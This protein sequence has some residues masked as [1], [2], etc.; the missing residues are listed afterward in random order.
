VE[1]ERGKQTDDPVGNLL[2]YLRETVLSRHPDPG[3]HVEATSY[4]HEE[5]AAVE[6]P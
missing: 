1:L 6:T 4:P 3:K 5:P 2:G